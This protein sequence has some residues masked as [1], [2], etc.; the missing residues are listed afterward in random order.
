MLVC[1]NW[2]WP[3]L[4][5]FS[6]HYCQT[7]RHLHVLLRFF[8]SFLSCFFLKTCSEL[9]VEVALPLSRSH[10]H[11]ILWKYLNYFFKWKSTFQSFQSQSKFVTILCFNHNKYSR[12]HL[13]NVY[14]VPAIVLSMSYILAI[15]IGTKMRVEID[16][17]ANILLPTVRVTLS[18]IMS[19]QY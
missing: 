17:C 19:S 11:Y 14:Y 18:D 2:P 6:P 1:P 13:L 7:S 5:I 4:I 3:C 15:L 16:I 9:Y 12:F 10:L 8:Q